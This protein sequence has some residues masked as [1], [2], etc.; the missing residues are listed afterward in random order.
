MHAVIPSHFQLH[1]PV[2]F[3]S[4]KRNQGTRMLCPG[5]AGPRAA[6]TRFPCGRLACCSTQHNAYTTLHSCTAQHC[7]ALHC[8]RSPIRSGRHINRRGS[9]ESRRG[10]CMHARG[11]QQQLITSGADRECM[12]VY[13]CPRAEMELDHERI[14]RVCGRGVAWRGSFVLS[15]IL[16]RSYTSTTFSHRQPLACMR[17]RPPSVAVRPG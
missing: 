14:A 9:R 8:R 10:A 11:N 13:I 4:T 1:W 12:A 15:K 16:L 6:R 7:T 5:R 17:R 2:S 3:S